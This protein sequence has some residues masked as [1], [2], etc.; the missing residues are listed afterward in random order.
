[1]RILGLGILALVAACQA[2]GTSPSSTAV[3][4]TA[5]AATAIA[6]AS[7]SSTAL[8]E[9]CLPPDVVAAL[10]QIGNGDLDTDPSLE[11]VADALDGLELEGAAGEARDAFVDR[12]REEPPQESY[13]VT[14]LLALRAQVAL[15]EC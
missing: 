2:P 15:P 11:A 10:D 6:S 8:A 9:G 7:P 14:A 12:L 5:S 4:P 3:Q 1:M 13:V